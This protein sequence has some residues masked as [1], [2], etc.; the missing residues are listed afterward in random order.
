MIPGAEEDRAAVATFT[1]NA[2]V[3]PV[4]FSVGGFGVQEACVGAPLQLSV[5]V[6]VNPFVDEIW[7]LYVAV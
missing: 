4:M 7:R 1:L 3:V 2:A 6:P 5:T